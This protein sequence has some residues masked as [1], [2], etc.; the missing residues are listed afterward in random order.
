M[1]KDPAIKTTAD[2][3]GKKVAG[4]KGTIL[5][6]ILIAALDKEGFAPSDV[7]F[8]SM[9]I[10]ESVNAMMTGSVDIALVAGADVLR[11]EK[12]RRTHSR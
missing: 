4:P 10:P 2:L 8:L 6:Q 3:K 9:G 7:K 11:A 12:S 1:A 5:H